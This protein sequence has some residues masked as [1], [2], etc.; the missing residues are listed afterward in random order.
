MLVKSILC[1]AAAVLPAT[2]FG[3][4][5]FGQLAVDSGLALTGLNSIA[6]MNSFANFK[7]SCNAATLK[8]RQEW[9]VISEIPLPGGR[10]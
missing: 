7:G 8:V 5:D 10:A 1:L 9:S 6:L 2:G 3:I 4:P